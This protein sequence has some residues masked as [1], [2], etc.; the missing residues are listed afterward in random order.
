RP[1]GVH[2]RAW[3]VRAGQQNA[4]GFGPQELGY[5]VRIQPEIGVAASEARDGAAHLDE[6]AIRVVAVFEQDDLV[7]GAADTGSDGDQQCLGRRGG[8]RDSLQVNSDPRAEAPFRWIR[9]STRGT[10]RAAAAGIGGALA[11]GSEV[12]SS[13]PSGDV[14]ARRSGRRWRRDSAQGIL[15]SSSAEAMR[16]SALSIDGC[17]VPSRAARSPGVSQPHS[18]SGIPCSSSRRAVPRWLGL[19]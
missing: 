7:A 2:H 17:V 16:S 10:S 4:A 18:A 19:P 14:R 3:I 15:L 12:C 1:G 5:C 8:Q 9:P 11:T 13:T 6:A